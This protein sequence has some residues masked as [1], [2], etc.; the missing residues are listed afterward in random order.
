[1]DRVEKLFTSLQRGEGLRWYLHRGIGGEYAGR[2]LYWC[3]TCR[4]LRTLITITGTLAR[5]TGSQAVGIKAISR[6]SACTRRLFI[7]RARRLTLWSRGPAMTSPTPRQ[8]PLAPA[9]R[10]GAAA[11]FLAAA[12]LVVE[13]WLS[14]ILWL[15]SLVLLVMAAIK[16]AKN[17]PTRRT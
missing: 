13:G 10:Y 11:L 8:W 7:I 15:A 2:P 12:A 4:K 17:W 14:I 3:A 16:L 6:A 9:L 5:N 1:M